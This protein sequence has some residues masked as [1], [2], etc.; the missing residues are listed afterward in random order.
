MCINPKK[1]NAVIKTKIGMN[2]LSMIEQKG[3]T[4]RQYLAELLRHRDKYKPPDKLLLL[5]DRQF[6][7]PLV[8]DYIKT[9]NNNY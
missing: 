2:I 5:Q 3:Q 4:D 6:D 8:W 9:D 7:L 1:S